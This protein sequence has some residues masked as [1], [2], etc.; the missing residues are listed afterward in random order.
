MTLLP[1]QAVPSLL[2]E[3]CGELVT[4]GIDAAHCEQ[5]LRFVTVVL[6]RNPSYPWTQPG[7]LTG[8]RQDIRT[9]PQK[10]KVLIMRKAKGC[11][12]NQLNH[13]LEE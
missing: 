8:G 3:I 9:W 7:L 2:A 11:R 13:L 10:D 12:I 4:T 6:C 5:Q 1:A